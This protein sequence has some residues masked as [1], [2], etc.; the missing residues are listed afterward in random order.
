MKEINLLNLPEKQIRSG[1]VKAAVQQ[2]KEK[3]RTRPVINYNRKQ[4]TDTSLRFLDGG[5]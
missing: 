5:L 1:N 3:K 4:V 2:Q